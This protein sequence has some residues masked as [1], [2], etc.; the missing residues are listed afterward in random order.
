MAASCRHV[1]EA[2]HGGHLPPN[3]AHAGVA[4]PHRTYE[5]L[6]SVERGMTPSGAE[7][8]GWV[9]LAATYDLQFARARERASCS[10]RSSLTIAAGVELEFSPY[11]DVV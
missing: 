6:G 5:F 3:D 7:E 8:A 9:F 1:R 11:H 4:K 10:S 2:S